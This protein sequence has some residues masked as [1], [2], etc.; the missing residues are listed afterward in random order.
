M[1][2]SAALKWSR[3]CHCYAPVEH[4]FSL[5][6]FF[7]LVMIIL[8]TLIKLRATKT[9]T[10]ENVSPCKNFKHVRPMA[11]T[12]SW[13]LHMRCRSSANV[14]CTIIDVPRP[15]NRM[16]NQRNQR[17]LVNVKIGITR[18]NCLHIYSSFVRIFVVFVRIISH[19]GGREIICAIESICA[20][21]I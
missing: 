3:S 4:R 17:H 15:K 19:R 5:R 21:L 12:G 10:F 18:A 6:C 9:I 11:G 13:L 20:I 1:V 8:T 14:P 7:F 16:R 2:S